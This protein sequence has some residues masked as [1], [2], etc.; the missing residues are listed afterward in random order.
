M[1][2]ALPRRKVGMFVVVLFMA[3]FARFRS[4]RCR[5]SSPLSSGGTEGGTLSGSP[6]AALTRGLLGAGRQ[7]RPISAA[8]KKTTMKTHPKKQH[9]A[10]KLPA[11]AGQPSQ[12]TKHKA[13]KVNVLSPD[14]FPIS[15]EPFKSIRA[16]KKYVREWVEGY[17]QQGYYRHKDFFIPL[18]ILHKC[19]DYEAVPPDDDDDSSQG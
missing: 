18:D 2:S 11:P 4:W 10:S 16:A 3:F 19:V 7:R 15:P 12:D 8:C 6:A 17:R 5:P 9:H 13:V 14:G 1:T